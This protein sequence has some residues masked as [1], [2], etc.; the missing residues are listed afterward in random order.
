ML[1]NAQQE[2]ESESGIERDVIEKALKGEV[3]ESDIIKK[4]VLCVTQKLEIID[5][6]GEIQTEA[7]K[8]KFADIVD[9]MDEL[10]EKC[11][12]DK[13]NA[14]D[15]AYNFA[16]CSMKYKTPTLKK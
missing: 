5:D 11:A 4:H 16:K 7:V 8:E 2:C 13:G 3:P 15:T 9:N 10:I 12:E 14:D 1:L 6:K